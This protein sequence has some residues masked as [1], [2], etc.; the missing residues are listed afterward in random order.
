MSDQTELERLRQWKAEATEVILGLQD[1]GKALNI[2]PGERITGTVAAHT[3]RRLTARA[4]AAEARVRELEGAAQQLRD[5]HQGEVERHAALRRN[6]ERLD[7][8][9]ALKQQGLVAGPP[10]I[11]VAAIR[12]WCRAALRGES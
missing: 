3:A 1:V 5:A 4:E 6:V 12:G 11:G 2:R 8:Q 10:Q 7:R 9:M